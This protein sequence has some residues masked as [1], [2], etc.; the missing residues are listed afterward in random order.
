MNDKIRFRFISHKMDKIRFIS[1]KIDKI[2][3]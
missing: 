2:S 1:H 3:E